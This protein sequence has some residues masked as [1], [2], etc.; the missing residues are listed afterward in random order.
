MRALVRGLFFC[1]GVSTTPGVANDSV[2]TEDHPTDSSEGNEVRTRRRGSLVFWWLVGND[3]TVYFL[4]EMDTSPFFADGIAL[5]ATVWLVQPDVSRCKMHTTI[6]PS[7]NI[8]ESSIQDA[9]LVND[10]SNLIS[11]GGLRPSSQ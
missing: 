5:K 11:E 10:R 6:R 3:V 1:I 8:V 9:T 7:C 2:Y 4:F